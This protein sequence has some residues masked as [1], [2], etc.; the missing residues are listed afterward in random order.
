MALEGITVY[1]I[2]AEGW[3]E[4]CQFHNGEWVCIRLMVMVVEE[5][6]YANGGKWNMPHPAAC[7]MIDC[8][9]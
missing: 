1:R 4:H 9:S 8:Q 5:A 2:D 7:P 3:I 6:Y